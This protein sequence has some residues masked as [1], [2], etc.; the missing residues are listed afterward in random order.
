VVRRQTANLLLVGSIP[1]GASR[2]FHNFR[3]GSPLLAPAAIAQARSAADEFVAHLRDTEFARLDRAGLA[4]VDYTGSA[5]YAERQVRSHADMLEKSVLGN[6]HSESGS[7]QASTTIIDNARVMLLEFLDASPDDYVV[8]FTANASTAIK[9]IAESFQFSREGSLVLSADN[10]NSMNGIREFARR[11]GSPVR[12]VP[13]DDELRLR[14]PERFLREA[15]APGQNLFGFPAQS[16]FSGVKHPLGLI[17]TAQNLGYAVLLD[18][19]AFVPANQLSLREWPADFVALS[20]YKIFGLPTGVGALV[21]RRDSLARLRRPW[22]AGGTVE[23]VSVQ[24]GTHLLRAGETGFEDGTLAFLN[25][26]ALEPGFDFIAEVGLARIN[27][28]VMSLTGELLDRLQS[29]HR[30][31]GTPAVRIYGPSNLRARGATVA[32]NVLGRNGRVVPHQE[33]ERKAR[34]AGVAIRAGCFCNP[35]ASEAAFGFPAEATARC[36]SV[37]AEQGFSIERFGSC[38]GEEFTVGAVRA[39]PGLAT[40]LRD[41]ERVVAVVSGCL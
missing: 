41:V 6:P 30:A 34:D 39:S 27:A 22:F 32:F 35:G 21:A 37:A 7:S 20:M 16:N 28:H 26:A 29:L 18:A 2:G 11:A 8:C 10:H 38:M 14:E 17:S 3:T 25:I 33:V 12:Y 5:L 31:D 19:A 4:Y 36:F 23:F 15:V 24:N 40:N 1:T 13:L 9:L